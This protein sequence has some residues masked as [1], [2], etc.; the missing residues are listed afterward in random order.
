MPPAGAP[1]FPFQIRDV[2]N[3]FAEIQDELRSQYLVS[4]RPADLRADGRY[5]T[6]EIIP[7]DRKNLRVRSRRGWFAPTQ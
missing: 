7:N 5:R 3:A 4:Y 1:S 2:V 6:I